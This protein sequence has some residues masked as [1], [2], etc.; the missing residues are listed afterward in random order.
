MSALYILCTK[1]QGAI[2]SPQQVKTA[3]NWE[4][5]HYDPEFRQQLGLKPETAVN[6]K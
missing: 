2:L 5:A 4:F 3:L 1:L 6:K